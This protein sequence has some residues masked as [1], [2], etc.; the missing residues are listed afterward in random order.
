MLVYRVVFQTLK[1]EIIMRSVWWSKLLEKLLTIGLSVKPFFWQYQQLTVEYTIHTPSHSLSTSVLKSAKLDCITSVLKG[2]D[3]KWV[4]W[5]SC[6]PSFNIN[7]ILSL[8]DTTPAA[9]WPC[10][11]DKYKGQI[12]V[13]INVNRFTWKRMTMIFI[14]LCVLLNLYC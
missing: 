14:F 9:S 1:R 6:L 3:R 11:T 2:I 10:I 4:N 13:K 12:H 7:V 8:A 5:E